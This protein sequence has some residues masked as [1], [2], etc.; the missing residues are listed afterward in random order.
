MYLKNPTGSHAVEQEVARAVLRRIL[1]AGYGVRV[2]DGEDLHPLTTD[3][4]TAWDTMGETDADR[5]KVYRGWTR[6]GSILLIWGNGEDLVSDWSWITDG[7]DDAETIM[8]Q[9]ATGEP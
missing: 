9:L 4:A 8:N 5:L 3:E 6:I 2:D 7:E 1:A